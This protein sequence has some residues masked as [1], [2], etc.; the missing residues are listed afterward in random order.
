MAAPQNVRASAS[1]ASADP[2]LNFKFLIRWDGKL[3]AGVSKVGALTRTTATEEITEGG[4]PQVTRVVPGRTKY[5]DIRLERGL[6]I[7]TSFELWA[8]R[9]WFYAASGSSGEQVSLKGFRKDITIQICNQAGQVVKQYFV[10]KCW[11]KEYTG[12]PDLDAG[13]NTVALESMTLANEG[14]QRDDSYEA[15]PPPSIAHPA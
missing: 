4:V 7:D 12:L 14:W 11:P 13:G 2:L 10:Y 5:G 15:K 3:V 1:P 6:I 9:V 8:N